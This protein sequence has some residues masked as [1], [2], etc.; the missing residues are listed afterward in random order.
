MYSV[1]ARHPKLL[2]WKPKPEN[3]RL[4]TPNE[5]V[6]LA[7]RR[8]AVMAEGDVMT[9]SDMSYL[10]IA[11]SI[12]AYII[13]VALTKH[14]WGRW[15]F[16]MVAASGVCATGLAVAV[17]LPPLVA[18]TLYVLGVALQ[19]YA[20]GARLNDSHMSKLNAIWALFP[21][22]WLALFVPEALTVEDDLVV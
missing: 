15:M 20:I 22:L 8:V 4:D 13:V 9:F 17:S 14:R 7:R 19:G 5:T 10:A 6:E 3:A 12:C 21:F 2:A 11:L 16:L 1:L 18:T